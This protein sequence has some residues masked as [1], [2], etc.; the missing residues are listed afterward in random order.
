M[1]IDWLE[2]FL[3][4]SSAGIFAKA[5]YARN[6]SQS[7][8]TRRIRNLEHWVGADLFDR[9]VHPVVLTP[10]GEAFRA[11]AYETVCSLR[12]ARE[13][14]KQLTRR[15]GDAINISALH[16]LAISFTPAWLKTI[17]AAIGPINTRFAVENFS[18]CVETLMAGTTDFMLCY[19]HPSIATMSNDDRYP[20]VKIAD[21]RL[22]AVSGTDK[23]GNALYRFDQQGKLP[24][25]AYSPESFLGRLSE[26]SIKRAGVA[27]K[28]EIRSENSVAEAQKAACAEGLGV[29]WLPRMTIL[30]M[31]DDGKLVRISDDASE[32]SMSIKLYRSIERS[33]PSVERFWKLAESAGVPA[34]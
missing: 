24:F 25:L 33:R 13:D 23:S 26:I 21:D 17:S 29:A 10:A 8:F 22:V 3:A 30:P 27:E 32:R 18:D 12:L 19:D 2:D 16:T 14:L 4:L 31:L 9:S 20:S 11:T 34:R 7:A 28:L 15:A 5:A 1:E 6:I